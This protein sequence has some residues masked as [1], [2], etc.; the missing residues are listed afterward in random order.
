MMDLWWKEALE[1]IQEPEQE[2]TKLKKDWEDIWV[3]EKE[4][5]PEM[6]ECHKKFNGLEDKEF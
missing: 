1:S 4:K 5:E 6:P 3:K 2:D